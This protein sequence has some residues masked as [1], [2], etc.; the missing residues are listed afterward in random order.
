MDTGNT[1]NWIGKSGK[2]YLYYVWSLP[3][4]FNNDQNG[5]YIFAKLV[6]NLWIPI[7]IGQG[8]IGQRVS[9]YHHKYAC[10]L[11]KGATHVHVH[12]N[13]I[14]MYRESEETDL[15]GYYTNTFE[16]IGCNERHF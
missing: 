12:L 14:Q 9:N 4:T 13:S 6:N 16:P 15:L 5:N 3:Q 10:I 2:S 7:Y 8:D 1:C 11:N